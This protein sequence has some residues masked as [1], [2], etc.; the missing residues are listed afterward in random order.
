ME[1]SDIQSFVKYYSR[2]KKRT[3][4]LFDYIP[5]DKMEW[6]YQVGKFT[7]G[8]LIRHLANIERFMYAETVQFKESGYQGCGIEF[9]EGYEAVVDYYRKMHEESL[10]IFLSLSQEDLH[11]K[12]KTPAG[13]EITIW[14][15]LRAMVEHEVH[16]RG[17][18]YTYLAILGVKTPPIFGL[19]S[20]EVIDKSV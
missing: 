7:I 3:S 8:D 4:R 2:I 14:K 9:A 16:H 18:L 11:K 19:T 5:K 1:I 13:T 15:W 17:Q 20:E 10:A 6:T 12:C